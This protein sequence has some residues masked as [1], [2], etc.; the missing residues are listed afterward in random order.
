MN[1]ATLAPLGISEHGPVGCHLTMQILRYRRKSP[2]Q[3]KNL[4]EY[5]S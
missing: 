5:W 4:Q 2:Q 1:A 3:D